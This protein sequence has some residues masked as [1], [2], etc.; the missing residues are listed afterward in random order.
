MNF[1]MLL[2]GRKVS[3]IM[4]M[5][6]TGA[7]KKGAAEGP[8]HLYKSL[9]KSSVVFDEVHRL[10]NAV[11]SVNNV[12]PYCKHIEQITENSNK[13]CQFVYDTCNEGKLPLIFSGDHSNAIGGL[14]GLKCAYPDKRIGVI[15][16]DAHADLHSPYTTPSGNMHGM[17]LAALLAFDNLTLAKN[18]ISEDERKAWDKL[19]S[20]G[21]NAVNPK[22][23]PQDL[24]FIGLRDAES[25]EWS[26]IDQH[27]IKT[28]EPTD[29]KAHA[30]YHTVNHALKHL[31]HCDMLYVSFDVDSMDPNLANGTGTPVEDGLSRIE[32]ESI[33]K[34]LIN[35]PKLAA[36]EITEINPSLD[37]KEKKMA[38]L[39]AEIL[40]FALK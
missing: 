2:N 34:T 18:N 29:I 3:L 30:I 12:H 28:F 39:T 23:F 35:H 17:P 11:V 21:P 13:L 33:I 15:W 40:T 7:G 25:Q 19:K 16:V 38:D 27:G 8:E 26:L 24:V 4:A 20:L 14:S 31:E 32:S 22:I 5:F 10:E 36:F 9:A 37:T 6:D 1:F